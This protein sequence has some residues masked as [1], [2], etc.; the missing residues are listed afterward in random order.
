MLLR[1]PDEAIFESILGVKP[2]QAIPEDGFWHYQLTD[3]AGVTLHFSFN[4]HQ[5]SIQTSL[6]LD[7]RIIQTVVQEGASIIRPISLQGVVG[8]QAEFEYS[9]TKSA[10]E[11]FVSPFILVK[12]YTLLE[13]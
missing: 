13:V 12:W 7:G 5:A 4:C 8:L 2:I 3:H 9:D 6:S 1:I 10:L 11:I